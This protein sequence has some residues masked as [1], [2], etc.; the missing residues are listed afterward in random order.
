MFADPAVDKN[1][2]EISPE[3]EMTKGVPSEISPNVEMTRGV[4]SE[5]LLT[6]K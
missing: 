4:P 2:P 3:V 6:S 1:L 5:F